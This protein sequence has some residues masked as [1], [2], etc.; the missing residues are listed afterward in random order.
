MNLA[1][2]I[3]IR[4]RL[5]WTP[6]DLSSVLRRHHPEEP[7]LVREGLA[8]PCLER[9]RF[10][11]QDPPGLR[12]A[13]EVCDSGAHSKP[14]GPSEASHHAHE[15]RRNVQARGPDA[16]DPLRDLEGFDERVGRSREDVRFPGTPFSIARR[17]PLAVSS[18]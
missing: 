15:S 14:F 18:T 16:G 10:V 9:P 8:E 17:W 11:P 1:A 5:L 7:H 2:E 4:K 3:R 6:R 13:P 12:V